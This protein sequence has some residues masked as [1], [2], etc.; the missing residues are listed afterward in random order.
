[1]KHPAK[2]VKSRPSGDFLKAQYFCSR[3]QRVTIPNWKV[4]RRMGGGEESRDVIY[5]MML[6]KVGRCGRGTIRLVGGGSIDSPVDVYSSV[7]VD[8]SK[9]LSRESGWL[10][11]PKFFDIVSE[12]LL[13]VEER[14]GSGVPWY[15]GKVPSLTRAFMLDR[16]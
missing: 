4:V 1:M 9:C 6:S 14:K 10:L 16:E 2:H 7:V 11:A 3:L 15:L 13:R 12:P 8:S 5:G